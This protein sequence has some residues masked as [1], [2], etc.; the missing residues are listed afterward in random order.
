VSEASAYLRVTAVP[1]GE[2]PLSVRE[3]WVGLRLPL[4][5]RAL[6]P[7]RVRTFGVVSGPRGALA[8]LVALCL[9]RTASARGYVVEAAPA[10]DI[11]RQ[12]SPEAAAWWQA[13]A[14]HMLR[15]RRYFVFAEHCGQVEAR[16]RSIA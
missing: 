10:I 15:P 14:P 2:A 6:R 8:Q 11:L 16:S 5:P 1:E 7:R 12:Q 4:H 9:G 3:Q 13:N